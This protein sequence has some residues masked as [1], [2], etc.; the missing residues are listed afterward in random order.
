MIKSFL[1][2][3]SGA[4]LTLPAME[5]SLLLAALSGCLILKMNKTGLVIAYLFIYRWTW[6]IL[7]DSGH[8]FLLFYLVFGLIVAVL[9]VIGM[10]T[11][12]PEK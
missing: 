9:T 11:A 2:I 3:M 8:E 10:F 1:D 6:L 4:T 5:V 12:S 7:K